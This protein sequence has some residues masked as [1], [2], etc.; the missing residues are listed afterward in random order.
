[1]KNL[2]LL[3]LSVIILFISCGSDNENEGDKV[4][5]TTTSIVS[6]W[7]S[8]DSVNGNV[9]VVSF[10]DKGHY[11]KLIAK[12]ELFLM[13][14]GNYKIENQSIRFVDEFD[15][16]KNET[17][18]YS[19]KYN[20]LLL[21]GKSYSRVGDP[22]IL[23]KNNLVGKKY[24]IGG[25]GID[26]GYKHIGECNIYAEFTSSNT[27]TRSWEKVYYD[28]PSKN[29]SNRDY[30]KYVFYKDYLYIALEESPLAY[31]YTL[32]IYSSKGAYIYYY[33]SNGK[34]QYF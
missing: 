2:S 4:D 19:I 29:S 8:D 22:E 1:M 30:F 17:L 34:Q 24:R 18:D 20:S 7:E 25:Y 27:L 28:E 31:K 23:F 6:V 12:S 15:N 11:I 13:S 16:S 5:D 33:D 26:Y 10:D 14:S 21:D 32:E 9:S 3:F